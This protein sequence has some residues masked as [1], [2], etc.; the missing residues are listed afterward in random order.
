[1]IIEIKKGESLDLRCD[2]GLWTL[3]ADK[4][5]VL[6]VKGGGSPSA[7]TQVDDAAPWDEGTTSATSTTEG[8]DFD[9]DMDLDLDAQEA[10][11]TIDDVMTS[12]KAVHAKSGRDML[13]RLL[14]K[15]GASKVPEVKESDYE[16]FIDTANKI[17]AK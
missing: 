16:G 2:G 7:Q 13:A 17:L 14:K 6:T 1:M 10:G 4:S 3:S 12:A 8:D 15:Y 5:G 11:P 9:L